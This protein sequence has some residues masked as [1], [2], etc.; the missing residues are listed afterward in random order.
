MGR[1]SAAGLGVEDAVDGGFAG[2]R[3]P[4]GRKGG[5]S[6]GE[7]VLDE[8]RGG[9]VVE[10]GEGGEAVRKGE[11]GRGRRSTGSGEGRGWGAAARPGKEE[12][13]SGPEKKGIGERERK[14]RVLRAGGR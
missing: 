14:L 5:G 11:E 9:A 10:Q 4:A 1:R 3:E 8:G 6:G 12:D 2:E 7:V 13:G